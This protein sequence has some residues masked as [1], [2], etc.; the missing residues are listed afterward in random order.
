MAVSQRFPHSDLAFSTV[1]VPAVV[2]KVDTLIKAVRTMRMLSCISKPACVRPS[3]R[4]DLN[5]AYKWSRSR[6]DLNTLSE[7]FVPFEEPVIRPNESGILPSDVPDRF[8]SWG[9]FR[10]PGKFTIS[11]VDE[12]GLGFRTLGLVVRI[13]SLTCKFACL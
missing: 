7:V 5:L 3:E 10:L 1:V 8:V 13:S 11:P 4:S 2:E 6:G 12:S 9:S